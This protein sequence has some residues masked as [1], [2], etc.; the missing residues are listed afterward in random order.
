MLVTSWR[1]VYPHN[2][3]QACAHVSFLLQ[4]VLALAFHS[5]PSILDWSP[6]PL[7]L[8]VEELRTT[9]ARSKTWRS[10]AL[11]CL[12][13]GVSL[14][15]GS[16]AALQAGIML[17]LDGQEGSSAL[18]AILVTMISGAQ[19]IGLHRVGNARLETS[20]FSTPSSGDG[21]LPWTEPPHVRT[22][23]GIRIW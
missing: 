16:I 6:T 17:L 19:R 21:S 20:P 7:A 10:L 18:D 2:S 5:T 23:I 9:D 1:C 13:G 3:H 4:L 12:Q 22:E 8:R 11:R 14:F 15:N